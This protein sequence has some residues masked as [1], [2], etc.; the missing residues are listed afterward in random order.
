MDI[1]IRCLSVKFGSRYA[2]ENLDI[3]ANAGEITGLLGRNGAGKT[4]ALRVLVGLEHASSGQ[5]LIA[6]KRFD[7]LPLGTVGVALSAHFPPTRTVLQQIALAA[8]V[9]GMPKAAVEQALTETELG[10]VAYK[11]AMKLSLGMKQRLMLACATIAN[12]KVLILDEP[13]NG[14]DPDGIAWLHKF[15]RTR[16]DQGAAVLVST[17]FLRDLETY[18]DK[19]VIMQRKSLWSG[20]WPNAHEPSLEALFNRVTEGIEI[21]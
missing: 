15:M 17:H 20:A 16:A 18:A 1:S 2:I 5:A 7:E 19:V 14:L 13:V 8:F 4:T 21:S 6:G 10:D 12:P 9:T 3:T 11:R